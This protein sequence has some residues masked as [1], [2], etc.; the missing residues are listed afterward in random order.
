M[1]TP[2]S[3]SKS[4]AQSAPKKT[5]RHGVQSQRPKV[6]VP[7][8][9]KPHPRK[10]G[11]GAGNAGGASGG[12]AGSGDFP[13]FVYNGGPVV[14]NPQV[15]NI[16]LG[17]WSAASAQ[18]RATNLNQFISDLMNSDYMNNSAQYGC[19]ST[20]TFQKGVF[21]ANS[22]TSLLDSDLQTI[23]QT[24]INNNTLPEP[25]AGSNIVYVFCLD[26][27]MGVNDGENILLRAE[28]R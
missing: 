23:I 7:L 9:T 22:S 2:H 6:K 18:T 8:G 11:L 17:D 3:P 20:G 5:V 27:N 15:Y 19:G 10:N 14:T 4:E 12:S 28:R 13:F 24:A 26:D 25:V 16:F 1:T 21:I